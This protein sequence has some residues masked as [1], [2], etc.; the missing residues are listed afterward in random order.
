VNSEYTLISIAYIAGCEREKKR[1]E[2]GGGGTLHSVAKTIQIIV[3]ERSSLFIDLS[4]IYHCF[5][6]SKEEK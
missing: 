6:V 5:R 3:P 4:I 1:R 2:R